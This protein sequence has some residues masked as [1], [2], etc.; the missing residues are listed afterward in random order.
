MSDKIKQKR[1]KFP[2]WIRVRIGVGRGKNEVSKIL[3]E[4]NLNT[5]CSSAGCPNLDECWR[6]NT[7]TFMILG[8][9]CTRNCRFCAVKH[10]STPALPD[11]EEPANVAEAS[12]RLKLKYVVITSVT[13]DDLSD[14][15][16]SQFAETIC[17]IRRRDPNIK[18]EVLTPDYL[19]NNLRTVLNANPVVFNHNIETVER[20]SSEI[21]IKADYRRSLE[22]LK[23]AAELSNG[24]IAVKSGLMVGMG[25][26]DSEVETT[27]CD[28]RRTGASI[29]TIGQYLPPSGTHWPLQRYVE[30]EQ[31]DKWKDFALKLGFSSVASAPLVRS[32]YNAD[33][34]EIC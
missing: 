6:R 26:S 18:T 29:L 8:E 4:L 19:G 12:L 1:P 10:C 30:P 34:M 33:R 5:V 16:S 24:K 9:E 2:P 31:F 27:I 32:S 23:S 28:I 7:A 21:R 22:V 15:G 17:A 11:P 13:R 25:E 14:G 3:S 20:L